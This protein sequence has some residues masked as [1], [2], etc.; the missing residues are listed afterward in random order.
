MAEPCTPKPTVSAITK[1]LRQALARLRGRDFTFLPQ[2]CA[3]LWD[4]SLELIELLMVIEEELQN[5]LRSNH[6]LDWRSAPKR[7][8]TTSEFIFWIE[9]EL[10]HG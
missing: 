10:N 1:A 3:D 5:G 8:A 9:R 7:T 4:D 2:T 6:E